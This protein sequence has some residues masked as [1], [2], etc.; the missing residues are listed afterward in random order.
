M[1]QKFN[2][3]VIYRRC[4]ATA[5]KKERSKVAIAD[6]GTHTS[7]TRLSQAL[8]DLK[9]EVNLFQSTVNTDAK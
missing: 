9:N 4:T 2:F 7:F 1:E 6:E 5:N 8:Q 3:G